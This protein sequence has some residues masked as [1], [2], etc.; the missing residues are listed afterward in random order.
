MRFLEDHKI[1][2][3]VPV[4]CR[5][6]DLLAGRLQGRRRPVRHVLPRQPIGLT[7]AIKAGCDN[8]GGPISHSERDRDRTR[9]A[10]LYKI[11]ST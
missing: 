7:A 10:L 5:G 3:C 4:E 1:H 9:R 8:D 11:E 2:L 6:Q